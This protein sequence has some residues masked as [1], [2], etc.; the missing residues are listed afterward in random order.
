MAGLGTADKTKIGG[1][2]TVIVTLSVYTTRKICKNNSK[3]SS[4]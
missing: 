1:G 3:N 4:I 2:F